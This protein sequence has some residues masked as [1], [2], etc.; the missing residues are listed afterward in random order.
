MRAGASLSGQSLPDRKAHE[1]VRFVN[2]LLNKK[3]KLVQIVLHLAQAKTRNGARW[4]LEKKT[5]ALVVK[6]EPVILMHWLSNTASTLFHF[7]ATY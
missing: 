4:H 1:T 2:L 3:T 6:H 5:H 7:D